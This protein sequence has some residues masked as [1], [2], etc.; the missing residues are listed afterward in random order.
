MLYS[1]YTICI[2]YIEVACT[3]LSKNDIYNTSISPVELKFTYHSCIAT[4]Q[5]LSERNE[6]R[7]S[8]EIHSS[9]IGAYALRVYVLCQ[10]L[11]E[12]AAHSGGNIRKQMMWY[13]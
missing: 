3:R 1:T 4:L 11:I 13:F 5:M 6:L 7:L 10:L 8:R 2:M 9:K 12:I